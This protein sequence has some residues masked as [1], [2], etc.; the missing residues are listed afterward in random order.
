MAPAYS[1][2]RVDE[3]LIEAEANG[4]Y[5][6]IYSRHWAA[7]FQ[8]NLLVWKLMHFPPA[9][10]LSL[11]NPGNEIEM[12]LWRLRNVDFYY[13]IFF[14]FLILSYFFVCVCL[15]IIRRCC[16]LPG[17]SFARGGVPR[18]G[19]PTNF[20]VWICG[21]GGKLS[22]CTHVTSDVSIV[23]VTWPQPL[24]SRRLWGTAKFFSWLY[25]GSCGAEISGSSD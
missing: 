21:F 24:Q 12:G 22:R 11:W 7:H 1:W 23:A 10:F 15:M 2:A 4:R 16:L 6:T 5:I 25:I 18:G 13:H 3:Y 19:V 20:L 17:H 14:F 8:I 9:I